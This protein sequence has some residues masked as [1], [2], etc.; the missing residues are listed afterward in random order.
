MH[1]LCISVSVCVLQKAQIG[2]LM[3]AAEGLGFNNYPVTVKWVWSK[4]GQWDSG[5]ERC[6]DQMT[7]G[8]L[9]RWVLTSVQ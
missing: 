4:H 3:G 1:P 2:L 8:I 9:G 6:D 7:S 5:Q